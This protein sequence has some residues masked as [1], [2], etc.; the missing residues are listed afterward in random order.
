R[1]GEIDE[2]T[3][4][5]RRAALD[6]VGHLDPVSQGRD[7]VVGDLAESDD[8]GR[9]EGMKLAHLSA[10]EVLQEEGARSAFGRR[11]Q[12][13]GHENARD[14]AVD[15]FQAHLREARVPEPPAVGRTGVA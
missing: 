15:V 13:L 11:A 12:Y 9:V 3:V 14:P 2:I 8:L 7:D 5:E 10:V 1:T 4:E 6:R